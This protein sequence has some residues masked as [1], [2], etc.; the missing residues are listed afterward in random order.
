MAP[1]QLDLNLLIVLDRLGIEGSVSKTAVALG[2]SQSAVSNSLRRLRAH[3]DDEL[4]APVGGRMRPTALAESLLA[5]VRVIREELDDLAESR[6]T[7]TP[8]TSTRMFSIIASDYVYSLLL[9]R[10]IQRV[11]QL[12]PNIRVR[13][14]PIGER[15][16]EFMRQGR[17]DFLITPTQL[18]VDDHPSV[19]LFDDGYV[20]IAWSGNRKIGDQLTLAQYLTLDHVCTAMGGAHV[21]HLQGDVVE[22]SGMD[23]R[24]VAYAPNF[25]AVAD[26]ILETDMIATVH[27]RA[28][29]M[30]ARHLPLRIFPMP[31]PSRRFTESLQW[32]R[33]KSDDPGLVWMRQLIVETA[34]SMAK[35]TSGFDHLPLERG[36]D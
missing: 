31:L 15:T 3:F 36:L 29:M 9:T 30:Q 11:R 16:P 20:C 12:A 1:D 24:I 19:P 26:T 2:V 23:R 34:A 6:A 5:R 13:T 35:E 4:F 22:A 28:A 7:F 21:V 8:S 14:M 18:L 10:L 17:A 27:A 25:M 33:R 32:H